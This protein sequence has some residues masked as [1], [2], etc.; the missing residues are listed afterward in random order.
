MWIQVFHP[1]KKPSCNSEVIFI[2]DFFSEQNKEKEIVRIFLSHIVSTSLLLDVH[3][4][5]SLFLTLKG[6]SDD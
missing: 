2:Y 3:I 6:V 4:Q 5:L 1:F